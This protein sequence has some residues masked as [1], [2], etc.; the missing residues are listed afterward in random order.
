[1][2]K[3]ILGSVVAAVLFFAPA[4]GMAGWDI[5]ISIPLPGLFYYYSAPPAVPPQAA[6]PPIAEPG[7]VFYGGYWY[8][9][10][11]PQWYISAQVGGPWYAIGIESVPFAV[12]NIPIG[13]GRG[14]HG[15]GAVIH[16]K[17]RGGPGRGHGY[18][19][20]GGYRFGGH[21]D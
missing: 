17:G 14:G 5:S 11:G 1:M 9:P 12:L 7:P 6:V 2:K 20:Y 3:G 19:G 15:G 8:Q 13:H 21:H 10:A 4:A 18:D 16:P